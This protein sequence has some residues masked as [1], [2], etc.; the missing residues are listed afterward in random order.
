MGP[1]VLFWGLVLVLVPV[2]FGL[3]RSRLT[4]LKGGDWLLLGLGLSQAG[5]GV[6]L[7]VAGW[8]LALGL[9]SR[10]DRDLPPW[11]FNLMQA[12]LALLG[13]AALS[14]LI[15]AVHQGLLGA[16]RMQIAGNGSTAASLQWYKDRS[17]PEL[18]QVWLVSVPVL[19][20]R[21]LMLAW[22][23]WLAIRLLSWLSWGWRSV[24]RPVLW[25]ETGFKLP[26]R[27]REAA[28]GASS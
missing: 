1:A 25:R 15:A 20:F 11:R 28:T 26:A 14:A 18:P 6:G 2:A 4:P 7:L 9:R 5:I 8:L 17:L 19:V 13:L 12:G 10:L 24:S 23:L 3:A 22:A 27:R 21:G 16:P